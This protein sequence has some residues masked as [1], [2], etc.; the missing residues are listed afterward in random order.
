MRKLCKFKN[1]KKKANYAFTYGNA[2]IE[3]IY[4]KYLN[5]EMTIDLER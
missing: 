5:E 1:C 4:D 2:D 3:G